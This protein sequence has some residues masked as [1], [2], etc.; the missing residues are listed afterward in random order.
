LKKE[1]KW[2]HESLLKA[3]SL[4]KNSEGVVTHDDFNILMGHLKDFRN[5]TET[6]VRFVYHMLVSFISK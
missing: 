1:L 2:R 3:F 5:A 6:Q 4:I